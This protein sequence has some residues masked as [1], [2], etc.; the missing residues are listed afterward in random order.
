MEKQLEFEKT[1]STID[2]QARTI[3]QTTEYAKVCE[4]FF[5]SDATLKI[6]YVGL[7][8]GLLSRHLNEYEISYK[9]SLNL[10][11]ELL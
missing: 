5:S 6:S 2:L 10:A 7:S 8:Y 3:I 1:V 4:F 11:V 9:L